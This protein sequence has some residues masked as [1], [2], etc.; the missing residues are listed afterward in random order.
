MIAVLA[1]A[2]GVAPSA[3]MLSDVEMLVTVA[4]VLDAANKK[5]GG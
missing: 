2:L 5:K 3:L 4:D 1:V